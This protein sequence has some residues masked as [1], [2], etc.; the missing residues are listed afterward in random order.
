MDSDSEVQIQGVDGQPPKQ[1]LKDAQICIACQIVEELPKGQGLKGF[2]CG[3]CSKQF[4]QH[5]AM[6]KKIGLT[7]SKRPKEAHDIRRT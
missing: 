7:V 4:Q 5:L 1:R 3:R 6:W 2:Y